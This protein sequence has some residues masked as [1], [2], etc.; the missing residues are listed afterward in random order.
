MV[1]KTQ[2]QKSRWLM[3]L[4]SGAIALNLFIP[5]AT[6]KLFD[7]PV[8]KLPTLERVALREGK[9]ILKGDDGE[10]TC[11]ILVN[12]SVDTAWQVLTDYDNF[13]NFLPSVSDSELVEQNGERKVFE[14]INKIRTLIFTT[15]SRVRIAVTESYPQTIDFNF[16]DGDLE[17]LDGTW[18]LEPVSPYPSAPPNQV[19]IT[20]RV[21]VA[22]GSTPS[23]SIFYNIYE[24]TLE[25]TLVAIKQ[26]VEIRSLK[27]SN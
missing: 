26:E 10:Y 1:L 17:S 20:H 4:L 23:R 21:K 6:A 19:L 7:G 3:A 12:G 8:D 24:N 11:R 16:V 15:K 14:Q 18:L 2:L 25:K 9:A 13:E 5:Q 22:P 27:T